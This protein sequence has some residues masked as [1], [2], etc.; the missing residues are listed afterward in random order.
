MVFGLHGEAREGGNGPD[1]QGE[2]DSRVCSGAGK[3]PF[4]PFP[5]GGVPPLGSL[6]IMSSQKKKKQ[7]EKACG[8]LEN[9]PS[10]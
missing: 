9:T 4:P 2:L 7:K 10:P 5:D 6:Q 1:L 8:K 3:D